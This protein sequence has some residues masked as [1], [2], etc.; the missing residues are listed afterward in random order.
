M[1]RLLREKGL[2]K[3]E[4]KAQSQIMR[5]LNASTD[6]KIGARIVN[7]SDVKSSRKSIP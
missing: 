2:L 7:R 6:E 5:Y 3:D 1:E 4:Q